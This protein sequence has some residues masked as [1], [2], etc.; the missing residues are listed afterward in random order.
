MNIPSIVSYFKGYLT[1]T[2]SGK[3]C[4]RF[5]QVC[6]LNSILL[7]DIVRISKASIRCKI[8]AKAFLH[9]RKIARNTNVSI[10][11]NVK[12]GFPFFVK[13]YKERKIA[14]FSIAIIIVTVVVLNQFVWGI[15]VRGNHTIPKE[16]II[17][18]LNESGLK[19]GTLKSKID[20][21]ELK[22]VSLLKIPELAWLWVDKKGSKIVVDVR[23]KILPPDIPA[24]DDYYNI[25]AKK[26][27]LIV[28]MTVKDG[29]P[30]VN[31]GETILAGTVLVTGKIPVPSKQLTRYVRAS[32]NVRARVWYEEKEI[33]S[34]ISTTRCETGKSKTYYTLDFFGNKLRLFHR[35]NAPY[36][37]YDLEEKSYS[38]FGTS[39]NKKVYKEIELKKEFL[40]EESVKDFGANQIIAKIEEMTAPD[41][42]RVSCDISHKKLNDTTIEVLVKAEY[43]ENIAQEVKCEIKEEQ[44]IID[45]N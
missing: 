4:E 8:S 10:H 43:L 25:V 22:K 38:F 24:P 45:L 40:T 37:N 12:H 9:L 7:W 3:F 44:E 31:T 18:V 14:L 27:A 19:I 41:S 39:L 21:Q 2:V 20:Q 28:E 16:K 17:S 1:I 5:I 26:D 11:I 30:V 32:A 34:T 6:A 29:V 35:D 15:E 23:E 36:K 33:F 13:K 42:Q